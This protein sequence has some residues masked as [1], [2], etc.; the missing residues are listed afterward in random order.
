M[1]NRDVKRELTS[2]VGRLASSDNGACILLSLL[3]G[4]FSLLR[5]YCYSPSPTN[6]SLLVIKLC[7]QR[8]S[9]LG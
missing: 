8:A 3:V 7:S 6:N 5:I 4:F 1:F 2:L 9:H